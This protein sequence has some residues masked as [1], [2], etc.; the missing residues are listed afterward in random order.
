MQFTMHVGSHRLYHAASIISRRID[1]V[2]V[3]HWEP[4]KESKL[5]V[6]SMLE[7]ISV[8][9]LYLLIAGEHYYMR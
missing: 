5:S 7:T 4:L 6:V 9:T 8:T 3:F 2:G 1:A